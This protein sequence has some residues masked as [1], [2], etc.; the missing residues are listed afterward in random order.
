MAG[1]NLLVTLR[2]AEYKERLFA[3][4]AKDPTHRNVFTHLDTTST[5]SLFYWNIT[6]MY[7]EG[8]FRVRLTSYAQNSE[9]LF[10]P[11]EKKYLKDAK[12]RNI[13]TL[14]GDGT[15]VEES[16]DWFMETVTDDPT[17]HNR[18]KFQNALNPE[19]LFA[20]AIG[21]GNETVRR[22]VYSGITKTIGATKKH[23]WDLKL[24]TPN[25]EN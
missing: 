18:Y 10:S 24:V 23:M 25:C 13:Y 21:T 1:E 20:D 9:L 7:A 22:N 2:N 15:L 4:G 14:S 8:N 16:A 11:S 17:A 19:Y 5:G 6:G 3:E 12:R